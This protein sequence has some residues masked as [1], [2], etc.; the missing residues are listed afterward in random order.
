MLAQLSDP[1]LRA[2][3]AAPIAKLAAANVAALGDLLAASPQVR[4]VVAGHVHRTVFGMLGGCPVVCCPSTNSYSELAPEMRI[5]EEPAG[6][7]V[8]LLRDGELVTHHQLP[9]TP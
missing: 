8:H 5:V 9:A 6:F 2:G 7:L 3:D 1:H 4:R